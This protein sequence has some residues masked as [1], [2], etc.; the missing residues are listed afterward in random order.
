MFLAGILSWW[1]GEGLVSRP[2][3]FEERLAATIDFF[4]IDLMLAN[5]FSPFR[6]ISAGR[7]SG[8]SL[9]DQMRAFFD[10]LLSRAIG[11]FMRLVMIIVG[12]FVI[13]FQVVFGILTLII[14]V[15][16]P[17]LPVVGLILTVIGRVF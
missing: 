5:L 10:R 4:S 15:I 11:A 8:G 6:Q 13:F 2:K 17:I 16:V 12:I 14:W 3:I 7:L 9:E 1:Y